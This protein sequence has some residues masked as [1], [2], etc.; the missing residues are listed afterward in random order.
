MLPNTLGLNLSQAAGKPRTAKGS[1][2][3]RQAI[4]DS[5][6]YQ[7]S[8]WALIRLCAPLIAREQLT[9]KA[10]GG[11]RGVSLESEESTAAAEH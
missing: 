3:T 9:S 7:S 1:R 6:D 2:A 8:L 4:E 11:R 10:E 5:S